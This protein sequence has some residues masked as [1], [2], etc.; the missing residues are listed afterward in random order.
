MGFFKQ[1]FG[2]NAQDNSQDKQQ[3]KDR[4]FDVLK[5]DGVKAMNMGQA[6]YAVKCF[7]KALEFHED[8]EIHD[9]LSQIYIRAD[10][11]DKALE[12][13]TMLH[14]AQPDNIRIL[15]RMANI[16]Y[17]IEDY[18][19][20]AEVSEKA[21]TLDAENA[22]AIYELARAMRGKGD[23][24]QAVAQIS[25]CIA[26]CNKAAEDHAQLLKE[27]ML[28]RGTL[29][30]KMGDQTGAEADA[31]WLREN[32]SESEDAMMFIARVQQALGHNDEALK[33]YDKVIS[34]N[35]FSVEAFRER[36]N[37]KLSM[38]DKQGAEEDMKSVLELDPEGAQGVSGNFEAIGHE[39]I[40][41][42]VEQSYKNNNPFLQ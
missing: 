27:A 7:D 42:Q 12:Q 30:L 24:I 39:D 23:M 29:L 5:Y 15:L 2:G 33:C 38:G 41:Q 8:L 34:L 4:D 36:G 22:Q 18:D 40:Q 19:H 14:E 35:P 3:N 6:D 20:M 11:M 16:Y 28:L 1:L 10:Q 9:Y 37:L 17:M 13:L 31:N 26:L 32:D 21:K 25:Q